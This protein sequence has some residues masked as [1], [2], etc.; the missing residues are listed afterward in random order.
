MNVLVVGLAAFLVGGFPT[1]VVLTRR[2]YGIDVREIGSGNTGATNVTRVFGWG[3]G[4][5]VFLVDFL[6]GYVPIWW[7]HSRLP[8]QPV[9]VPVVGTALVL[10]HCYSVFLKFRGGKGVATSVGALAAVVPL[11]A[12]AGAVTYVVALVTTKISAVGSLAGLLAVVL[13]AGFVDRPPLSV[14][15]LVGA[16]AVIVLVR[17]KPN[18]ERLLRERKKP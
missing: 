7:V 8:E 17:H 11:A 4:T 3:A 16:I 18:I 13:Y 15:Y 1:G 2:R 12:A 10:G 6:K 14:L 5:A 9:L